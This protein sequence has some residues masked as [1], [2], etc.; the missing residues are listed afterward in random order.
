MFGAARR[1][2]LRATESSIGAAAA[3]VVFATALLRLGTG[4]A[5]ST[6]Q[7]LVIILHSRQTVIFS[8]VSERWSVVE[9]NV[10]EW[11]VVEEGSNRYGVV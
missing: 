2:V 1:R 10:V 7:S 8:I 6:E 11:N 5:A 9:W 4:A 3:F